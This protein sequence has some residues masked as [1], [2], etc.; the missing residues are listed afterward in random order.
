MNMSERK[1][2]LIENDEGIS[3]S[4]R[5]ACNQSGIHVDIVADAHDGLELARQKQ[6]DVVVIDAEL[7]KCNGFILCRLLKYDD[8][9]R[10]I[11]VVVIGST[12]DDIET[13]RQAG[14]NEVVMKPVS[15]DDFFSKIHPLF[16]SNP[17][18][19]ES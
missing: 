6:H 1:I 13:G 5:D 16:P 8:R 2:L 9:F 4:L 7:P 17:N 3:G 19:Q 18:N 10:T 11:P 12:G 15:P 14:A